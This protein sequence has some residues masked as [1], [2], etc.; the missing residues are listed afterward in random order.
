[1]QVRRVTVGFV[2][3]GGKGPEG[4]PAK[5]PVGEGAP[6]HMVPVKWVPVR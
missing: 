1:M 5:Q 3:F 6:D 2:K 4:H